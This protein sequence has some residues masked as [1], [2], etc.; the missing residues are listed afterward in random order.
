MCLYIMSMSHYSSLAWNV[1]KFKCVCLNIGFCLGLDVPLV[2]LQLHWLALPGQEQD[3]LLRLQM[4]TQG[5]GVS[6]LLHSAP[7]QDILRLTFCMPQT[8]AGM[9]AASVL[10]NTSFCPWS[11]QFS[12]S[13]YLRFWTGQSPS[14]TPPCLQRSLQ[15]F[16]ITTILPATVLMTLE[17]ICCSL[18]KKVGYTKYSS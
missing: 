1:Y 13:W 15:S 2:K 16:S 11:L 12:E 14:S 4:P 7:L 9:P 10:T 3:G 17:A 8:W 6:F 18:Q 5:G